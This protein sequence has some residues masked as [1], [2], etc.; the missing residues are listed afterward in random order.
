MPASALPPRRI[1][2]FLKLVARAYP[3]RRL[4]VVVDNYATHKHAKAQTWL[5]SHPR[6]H[7]HFTP[8]SVSW[9]N[10]VEVFF[11]II[12]RQALRRGDFASVQELM[13]AIRRFC[14][15]WNQRC[16]PFTWTKNADQILTKLKRSNASAT[17]SWPTPRPK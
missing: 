9:L 12:E 7:L 13:A 6:I 2:G 17:H 10:L 15:S 5:T 4:H 14:D 11:A 3:R 16:H 1:P 8:T